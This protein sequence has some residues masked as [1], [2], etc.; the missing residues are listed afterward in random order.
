MSEIIV[1]I[2]IGGTLIL[3]GIILKIFLSKEKR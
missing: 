3:S 1:S 2:V